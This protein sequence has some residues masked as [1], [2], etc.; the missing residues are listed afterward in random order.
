MSQVALAKVAHLAHT[1]LYQTHPDLKSLVMIRAWQKYSPWQQE[2]Q[3]SGLSGWGALGPPI[4]LSWTPSTFH[5]GLETSVSGPRCWQWPLIF[6]VR[7]VYWFGRSRLAHLWWWSELYRPELS[8]MPLSF[9]KISWKEKWLTEVWQIQSTL[10]W[11]LT[12]SRWIPA[13]L[14]Y[15]T[16]FFWFRFC[17]L[18]VSVHDF[19]FSRSL[20][21]V[22]FLY[23]EI[24]HFQCIVGWLLATGTIL[25]SPLHSRY[26]TLFV[27]HLAIGRCLDCF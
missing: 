16:I 20:T 14:C 25:W 15:H 5:S 7:D 21:E 1:N 27:S 8:T 17:L 12:Q 11:L 22:W 4:F 24:H 9:V 13:R 23:N 6:V 10:N 19:F 3:G 18:F 2:G 26:G